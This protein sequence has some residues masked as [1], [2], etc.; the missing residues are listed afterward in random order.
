MFLSKTIKVILTGLFISLLSACGSGGGGSPSQVANSIDGKTFVNR[1]LC[2]VDWWEHMFHQEGYNVG[3]HEIEYNY[4]GSDSNRH[5]Y[6]F[7]KNN[8]NRGYD[9]NHPIRNVGYD[10]K[11]PFRWDN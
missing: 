6:V 8:E 10:N 2:P 9:Y 5:I 11:L 3:L 4:D 1:L 7:E